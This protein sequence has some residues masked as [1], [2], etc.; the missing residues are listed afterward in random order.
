MKRRDC[1][2]YLASLA[3]LM[4][5]KW[6]K[7]YHERQVINYSSTELCD[8]TGSSLYK[9]TLVAEGQNHLDVMKAT[10]KN[11]GELEVT[12]IDK[13]VVVVRDWKVAKHDDWTGRTI[14]YVTKEDYAV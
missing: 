2:K 8:I 5:F 13:S 10:I 11:T 9:R 14:G 3:G 7:K 4:L 1:F 12:K 6:Q